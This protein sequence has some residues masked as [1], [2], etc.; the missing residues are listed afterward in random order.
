VVRYL[1][2]NSGG[3]IRD[4]LRLLGNASLEA[5]ADNKDRIDQDSAQKAVKEMRLDLE[6]L[7]IPAQLYYPLLAKLHQSKRDW[8]D[9]AAADSKKLEEFRTIFQNL[10]FNGT[11]LEYNGEE[12]WY[13]VHPVIR[14]IK[15]F[16]DAQEALAHA[17]K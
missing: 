3:S 16:K 2:T 4:L 13:D 8:F 15:A 6:R 9:V 5:R 17:T 14:E 7:L 1:C 11:V 12:S 10:L